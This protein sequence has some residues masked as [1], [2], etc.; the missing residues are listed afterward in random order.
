MQDTVALGMALYVDRA[1]DG[2]IEWQIDGKLARVNVQRD[3]AAIA[4][5]IP[6][7][8][9]YAERACGTTDASFVSRVRSV[10]AVLGV[11]V[12]RTIDRTQAIERTWGLARELG[13]LVFLGGAFFD[14]NGSKL[15]APLARDDE[16]ES[17]AKDEAPPGPPSVARIGDRFRVLSA[18]AAR[19]L[20]ERVEDR[21]SGLE[22]LEQLRAWA[23]RSGLER[24]MESEERDLLFEPTLGA[25][26]RQ[27]TVDSIWR[28]EGAVV[29]GWALGLV[30]LPAHDALVDVASVMTASG[31]RKSPAPAREKPR[32]AGEI[33]AMRERLFSIHW[34]LVD[35]RVQARAIDFVAA[36]SRST[37]GLVTD[38]AMLLDGDLRI[39]DR[40]I[41]S[42]PI[43]LVQQTSSIARER[44]QAG[45]WLVGDDYGARY[46]S[47][48]TDT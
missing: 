5:M 48:G 1:V 14:A 11:E 36:A 31:I 8:I 28:I 37:F 42:A 9:G 30:E 35:F 22:R 24:E 32:S 18:I 3:P 10:R 17:A 6:G 16:K 12:E 25:L 38:A 7:L 13:A 34:R 40:P 47:V 43:D 27:S 19:G 45:N 21:A 23:I 33:L 29:L 26:G 44:H 41:A 4:S 46:S 20:L 2:P 15:A 39:V